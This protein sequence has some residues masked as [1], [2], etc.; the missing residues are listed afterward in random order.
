[1]N[2]FMNT[3]FLG[4]LTTA[5]LFSIDP[6]T[7]LTVTSKPS[8][9]NKKLKDYSSEKIKLKPSKNILEKDFKI[10]DTIRELSSLM[11]GD[12]TESYKIFSSFSKK[13][14]YLKI[15]NSFSKD[16]GNLENSTLK[17]VKEFSNKNI[18]TGIDPKNVFY[19]FSGPDIL[20]AHHFF[21][22]ARNFLLIGLEPCG[23]IPKFLKS[24]QPSYTE[25]KAYINQIHVAL[26]EITHY[27]FFRTIDM[28]SELKNT[29][30]DGTLH[31][32]L[33]FLGKMHCTPVEIKNFNISSSG[34]IQ[35][36]NN[37]FNGIEVTF[38]NTKKEICIVR[39]ISANIDNSNLS[40]NSG[41]NKFINTAKI[42]VTYIK[43][44]SYLLH[45]DNFSTF[46][47]FILNQSPAILQD[48]TGI[49]FR[50]FNK[51][52]DFK[53]FGM[54]TKPISM[55]S[56][57]YQNDLDSFYKKSNP[58]PLGFGLGYNFKNQ[59]SALIFAQKKH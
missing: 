17:K 4:V 44:A 8:V 43:G 54:Y 12:T 20:F 14:D 51:N 3:I 53:L 52:W 35:Y 56:Y 19:P 11:C 18:Y 33:F 32:I 22:D 59:N 16:W 55:F 2:K 45:M 37:T 26:Q 48:D 6:L 5:I 42:D 40:R 15:T 21:N 50:N 30:V 24:P 34:E 49:P 31:V 9:V 1:M 36:S 46:R 57:R 25:F 7:H 58:I 28:S 47:D 10:N 39:Y 41:L 27:S 38:L 23:S 13:E 29:Y